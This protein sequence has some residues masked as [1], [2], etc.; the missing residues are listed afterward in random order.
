MQVPYATLQAYCPDLPEWPQRWRIEE[1]DLIPGQAL[2]ELFAPFLEHLR[3]HSGLARK[4]LRRHRD[5]LWMLGGD[6]IRR[7]HEAPALREEAEL[8]DVARGFGG[9]DHAAL[10][11]RT[12]AG[13]RLAIGLQ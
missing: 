6:L 12:R 2:L 1:R 11:V 3:V 9:R 8:D 5:N 10:E 4:T 13:D 7:L